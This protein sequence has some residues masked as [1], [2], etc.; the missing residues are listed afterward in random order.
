MG[1]IVPNSIQ[2]IGPPYAASE[3]SDKR[4]EYNSA[5]EPRIN[6]REKRPDQTRT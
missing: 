3:S 6:D 1:D 2:I 4:M 5:D